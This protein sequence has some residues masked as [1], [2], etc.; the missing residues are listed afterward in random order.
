MMKTVHF[1][2]TREYLNQVKEAAQKVEMLKKRIEFHE[3]AGNGL[4]T[5]PEE[6]EVAMQDHRQKMASLADMIARVPKVKYQWIL[7]KRYVEL[8]DWDEIAY[9]GN[10]RYRKVVSAHGLA[11][12]EMQDVLV[13]AGIIAPEDTE[14]ISALLPEEGT[15]DTG[16]MED[17]LKYRE[18]KKRSEV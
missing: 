15:L 3:N 6:L 9:Q 1:I 5:L 10:M 17:Y 4:S 14:D 12:P 7:I 8:L 18:E 16:T 13:E 11:L 2:K